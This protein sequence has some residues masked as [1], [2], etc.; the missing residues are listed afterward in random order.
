TVIDNKI[1]VA[2]YLTEIS[3]WS[4]SGI[5]VVKD[6]S[7]SVIQGNTVVGGGGG[8]GNS[9][10]GIAV[11]AYY[12]DENG[13]S[14]VTISANDLSELTSAISI[15]DRVGGVIEGNTITKSLN[16]IALGET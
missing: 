7:D 9:V 1:E 16:G 12:S 11:D 8:E 15:A 2:R 10:T 6:A 5:T 4:T 14:D 3:S 13:I